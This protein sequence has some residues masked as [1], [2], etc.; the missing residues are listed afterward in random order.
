MSDDNYE[1][2]T[3]EVPKYGPYIVK[4]VRNFKNSKE[5]NI[6]NI[7]V[8][9]LCRCGK[10]LSKPFCDG[11]HTQ[12]GFKGE[13]LLGR[14]EDKLVHYVG[15]GITVHDNRGV[16]S[17]AGF[18]TRLLPEV[19]ERG[20]EPWIELDD[21]S[22]EKIL[23]IVKKC[24]SGALSCTIDGKLYKDFD[25]EP[26]INIRNDGPY[27]VV[28]GPELKDPDGNKPESHERYTLCRCGGSKNKPFCDG[29]HYYMK[30][31]DEKN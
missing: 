5:E 19:F 22:P 28:G 9:A 10:S 24:P 25:R 18:C 2:P 1:E 7:P 17:H 14:V 6:V 4:G 20:K 3:I 13:K 11:S 21:A 26:A 27:S 12:I 15:K 8:M 23:E 29:T 30:F 31:K 16:C